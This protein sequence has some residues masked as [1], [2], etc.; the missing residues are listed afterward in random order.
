MASL[1]PEEQEE[2][3][4]ALAEDEGLAERLAVFMDTR[5]ELAATMKPLIDEPVPAALEA[6]LTAAI[7]TA[8]LTKF[9]PQAAE[10][11]TTETVGRSGRVHRHRL[12]LGPRDR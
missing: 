9:T 8:R 6:S 1:A 7:A 4:T 12:R 10:P 2:I 11:H 5:D 3:E